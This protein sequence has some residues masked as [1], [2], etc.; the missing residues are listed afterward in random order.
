[1]WF[2]LMHYP[3]PKLST[4]EVGIVVTCLMDNKDTKHDKGM[5]LI[6]LIPSSH[7]LPIQDY[8]HYSTVIDKWR[9]ND[10]WEAVGAVD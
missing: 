9:R 2:F 3:K 7:R 8:W 5:Y 6:C 1:M 10:Q 4:G